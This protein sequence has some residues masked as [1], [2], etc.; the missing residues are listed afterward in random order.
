MS[1]YSYCVTC[2]VPIHP[3]TLWEIIDGKQECVSGHVNPP[4]RTK[5]EFL[6]D[7]AERVQVLEML[8]RQR[9]DKLKSNL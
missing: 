3:A 6:L 7:L 4:N 9:S 1:S 2:E 8:G 5:D